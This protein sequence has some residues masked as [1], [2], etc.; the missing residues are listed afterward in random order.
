MLLVVLHRRQLAYLEPIHD[1]AWDIAGKGGANS[2][3]SILSAGIMR[4]HLREDQEARV[5]EDADHDKGPK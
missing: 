3:A 5:I 2:L 1:T 4:G